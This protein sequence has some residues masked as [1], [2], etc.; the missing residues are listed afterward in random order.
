MDYCAKHP[1][2]A[3]THRCRNC[4]AWLCRECKFVD[5]NGVFCSAACSTEYIKNHSRSEAV[6]GQGRVMK[7]GGR[8]GRLV[9]LAIL[10]AAAYFALKHFGLLPEGLGL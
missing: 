10:I 2:A 3:A 5:G 9:L 7:S 4:G 8:L 1:Q 6:G